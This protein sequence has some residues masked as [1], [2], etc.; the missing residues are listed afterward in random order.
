MTDSE[1]PVLSVIMVS[2]NTCALTLRALEA[3]YAD[4]GDLPAEV[5]LVDNASGDDSVAEVR[6]R[7]PQ[8]RVMVSTRNLGFGAANNVAM[9]EARGEYFLLLNTDAFLRPG[10]IGELLAHA[11]KN[12]Q[13]GV[14]GPR[15]LCPDGTLQQS[16][17]RYTTPGQVWR[18][19]FWISS[20]FGGHRVWGDY[21]RWG[22]DQVREVDFVIG[23][24]MLVR[25]A[26]YRQVGGF[27][28][29]FFLYSEE[30]DWQWRMHQA[31]W[32]I[33]F[34]PAATVVHVGGASGVGEKARINRHFFES[35]DHYLRKHHGWM[36]L[37]SLRAAMVM[38][39][40]LRL[41]LWTGA[42]V[43]V[44]RRR[45]VAKAK[46]KLHGWLIVRQLTAWPQPPARVGPA[47]ISTMPAMAATQR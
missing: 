20:L 1:L 11:R 32:K 13:L 3:L 14:V 25:A 28:E 41:G 35:L 47:T 6:R 42:Y 45:A 30:C 15:T 46:M 21:R 23:A 27:D 18:E 19:N 12:P 34:T 44:P 43:T 40:S 39:C 31:G 9:R 26:C 8:V 38:G 17:F 2:F 5:L 33:G 29:S 16:C 24:C 4:L 22:H 37:L 10:A 36:G 7:Y